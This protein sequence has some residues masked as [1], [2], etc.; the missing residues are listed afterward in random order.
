MG[1]T[2]TVTEVALTAVTDA[3]LFAL[4][5][6]ARFSHVTDYRSWDASLGE[7]ADIA[8]HA[9]AG[10]L[11][12]IGFGADGS[13]R[14]LVRA[15]SGG[16]A[17]LTER[18]RLYATASSRPYLLCGDGTAHLSGIEYISAA[19]PPATV[20]IGLPEGRYG[21]TV[22]LIDWAAEPGAHD[23]PGKPAAGAL[24]DI[25]VLASPAPEDGSFRTAVTTFGKVR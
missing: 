3:G 23:G 22:H 21:V 17:A 10:D 4:W 1:N 25:V 2:D 7:D 24:P 9:A 16:P 19:P 18:E 8:G 12:P 11:V 20:P 5:T 15:D 6:P 13:F 14:F